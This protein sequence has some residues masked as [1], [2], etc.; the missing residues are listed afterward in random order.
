MPIFGDVRSGIDLTLGRHSR[1]AD[2]ERW[3]STNTGE[4]HLGQVII[5]AG[6]QI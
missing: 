1:Q 5:L 6:L 2:P 3:R 4:F